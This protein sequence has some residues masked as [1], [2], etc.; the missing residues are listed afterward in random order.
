MELSQTGEAPVW[1]LADRL[2]KA[3][4]HARLTQQELADHI[5]ISRASVVNYET[6]RHAPS[7][8]VLLSWSMA[9]GVDMGWLQGPPTPGGEKAS[10]RSRIR[11]PGRLTALQGIAASLA[12]TAAAALPGGTT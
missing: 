8:P 6:G 1:T 12:L 11:K 4:E 10:Y 9:T 3:R 7:R 5:G 2:R